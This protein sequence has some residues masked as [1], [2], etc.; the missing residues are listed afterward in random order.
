[1]LSLDSYAVSPPLTEILGSAVEASSLSRQEIAARAGISRRAL[2]NLLEGEADPRLSTLE[3]LMHVLG[4][5]L[6]AA[7]AAA[8]ALR[9]SGQPTTGSRSSHSRVRRLLEQDQEGAHNAR[10]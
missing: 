1:M 2:Y 4:L 3:A 6:V 5:Q 9:L 8:S 10:G 7:P